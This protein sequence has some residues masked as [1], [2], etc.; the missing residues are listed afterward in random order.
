MR[1]LAPAPTIILAAITL[2]ACATT[3]T[4]AADGDPLYVRD[5]MQSRV[6]PAITALWDVSNGALDD[7]GNFDPALVDEAGW[8]SIE[9]QAG[10]LEAVMREMA[11]APRLAAASPG[12][13]ATEEYE[14]SMARVQDLIDANPAAY[15][16][17]AAAFAAH[18]ARIRAAAAARDGALA[19]ELVGAADQVCEGCHLTFWALPE[20]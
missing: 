11:E 5:A 8:E 20:G 18:A 4:S 6:N 13:M 12:N 7:D 3:P 15:R 19:G 16:A 10:A 14:V 2:A 17:F 9:V 1:L